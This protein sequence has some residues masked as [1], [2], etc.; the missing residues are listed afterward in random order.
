MPKERKNLNALFISIY[1]M[2]YLINVPL[3]Q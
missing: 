2:K 3:W 1:N